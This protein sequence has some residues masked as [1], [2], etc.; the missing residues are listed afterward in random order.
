[1]TQ[2]RQLPMIVAGRYWTVL[3]VASYFA[4]CG[5]GL[6]KYKISGTITYGDKPVALGS[7]ILEPLE[8]TANGATIASV[9]ITGGRYEAQV[10]GG[11]HKVLI[12]DLS[13]E[14]GTAATRSLFTYEYH[15]QVELP[16]ESSSSLVQDFVIPTSHK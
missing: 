2:H 5:G 4:G 7:M 3:L 15:T 11:P 12:R 13:S 16:K 6:G 14:A 8:A 9:E 1:M 10:V